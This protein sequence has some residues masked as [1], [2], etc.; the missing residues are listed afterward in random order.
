M[1]W[2]FTKNL[3][4]WCDAVSFLF[5]TALTDRERED[6]L[7]GVPSMTEAQ[8][9]RYQLGGPDGIEVTACLDDP[10]DVA[11]VWMDLN[12]LDS[13]IDVITMMCRSFTIKGSITRV[14]EPRRDSSLHE[15][16]GAAHEG[17]AQPAVAAD[18]ASRRR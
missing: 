17:A 9:F 7:R 6:I 1:A 5:G 16:R 11:H 14:E 13:K 4:A 3:G 10:P 12:P 8:Q 2:I 15:E 18:V